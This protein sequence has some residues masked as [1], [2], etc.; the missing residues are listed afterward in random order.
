VEKEM[1]I[2]AGDRIAQ[3]LFTNIK[4]NAAPVE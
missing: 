4:S 3:L 2:E 1:Q